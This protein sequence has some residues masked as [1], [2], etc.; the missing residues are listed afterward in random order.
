MGTEYRHHDG[1]LSLPLPD[2]DEM[3]AYNLIDDDDEDKTS[4][5][6]AASTSL[7]PGDH[8]WMWCNAIGGI[9]YQHH[10][11]LI[12]ATKRSDVRICPTRTTNTVL[13]IADFTAPDESTFALPTSLAR[14]PTKTATASL[15]RLPSW[16]GV[17]VTIYHKASEWHKQT[18]HNSSNGNDDLN[19]PVEEDEDNDNEN[20][21]KIALQR[22]KFLI[23]NPHLLPRYE[24]LESNCE[25]VATWCRTGAF[26][27]QQVRGLI[28]GG[29]RNALVA[30]GT[31]TA[32]G[33]LAVPIAICAGITWSVMKFKQDVNELRWEER[34]VIL[35]N[36]FEKWL[37]N[38]RDEQ[39]GSCIV[40]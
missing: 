10:G 25:T 16:H 18:Y 24:L 28:D 3:E 11:I 35:N 40:S 34:T 7:Q 17:R 6:S 26:H 19:N 30:T 20:N 1:E 37:A 14:K 31:A 21:N 12:K 2:A 38:R 36:E 5:Q 13:H 39:N 23:Q 22:V 4:S 15:R 33:P 9:R 29:K 27:T 32:I 8:I